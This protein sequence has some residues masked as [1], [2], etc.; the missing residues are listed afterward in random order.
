VISPVRAVALRPAG[1]ALAPG[2]HRRGNWPTGPGT[3]HADDASTVYGSP[4]CGPG[5]VPRDRQAGDPRW[6]TPAWRGLYGLVAQQLQGYECT[7][8]RVRCLPPAPRRYRG[9]GGLNCDGGEGSVGT[10]DFS[11]DG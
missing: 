4:P 1:A 6:G 11:P 2:S 10:G 3:W 8:E 7:Y 9:A 5:R